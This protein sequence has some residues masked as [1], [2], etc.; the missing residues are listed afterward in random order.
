VELRKLEADRRAR[1]VR[2]PGEYFEE[3]FPGLK[4]EA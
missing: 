4:S 2:E 3:D 1:G